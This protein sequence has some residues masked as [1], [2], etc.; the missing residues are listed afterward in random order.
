MCVVLSF[1]F[2]FSKNTFTNKNH[3]VTHV[4]RHITHHVTLFL[5]IF[6]GNSTCH[7]ITI[8]FLKIWYIYI[9]IIYI[10]IKK[11]SVTCVTSLISLQNTVKKDVMCGVTSVK[12]YLLFLLVSVSM[13]VCK[14]KLW[15]FPT[16]KA[17]RNIYQQIG[18]LLGF[19]F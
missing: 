19:K 4:T 18:N 7:P 11:W 6:K 17:L 3:L 5:H 13:Q 9:Y 8:I 15:F 2:F 12:C 10:Y 14:K 16:K 1:K